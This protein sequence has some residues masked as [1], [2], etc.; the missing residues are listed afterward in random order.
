MPRR[1]SIC[2]HPEREAINKALVSG[3]ASNRDIARQFAVS[4]HALGRHKKDHLPAHPAEA[5]QVTE[6]AQATDLMEELE[7]CFRRINLLFDA[8][9]RWLRDAEN[10][11]QYDIGPRAADMS[12]TY[13]EDGPK[14]KRVKRKAK[15]SSLLAKVTSNSGRGRMIELVETKHADP[16]ELVLKTAARLQAQVELLAKL[17]GELAQEGAVTVV[18]MPEWVE[19]RTTILAALTPFPD[20]RLA[21]AHALGDGRAQD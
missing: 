6:T 15:L 18:L 4:H 1:C 2:T 5:Q 10:P 12:V 20:A 3:K 21:V 19:L 17:L 13:W 7:S 9:D 11:N 16:R 14:G 8:C